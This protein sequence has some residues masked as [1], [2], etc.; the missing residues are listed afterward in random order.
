MKTVLEVIQATTP[1]LQKNGVENPRLNIEHLLAH[2]LGKKRM[3]LYMEF[4]RPLEDRVLEPLRALVKRRAQGEPLQHLLGTVEF[5]GR[6]FLCD[7]RALVPR[8]ETEQ[9]CELTIADCGSRIGGGRVLD[10]GTGSGVI[11]LS[12]AA[13]WPE[14]RVE[15]ADISDDALALARE[16]AARLGLAERVPFHKSDLLAQVTGEFQLIVANLPY[17][18][19]S[20]IPSLAREVRHDPMLALTP[21]DDALHLIRRLIADATRHLRGSLALEIGHDQSARV[22]EALAAHNFQDIRPH[23][24]YQGRQRFVFAKYG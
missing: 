7:K 6:S 10:V 3:D 20:E 14:A 17:I 23:A 18:A 1:Y 13:A 24:D 21:G 2:V 12:L 5:L 4:D 16:N 9:L 11:A 19:A 8:P 22:C 15:A